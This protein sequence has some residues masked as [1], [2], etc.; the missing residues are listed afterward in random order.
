MHSVTGNISFSSEFE[1]FS[2]FNNEADMY[3][4][5]LY[6]SGIRARYLDTDRGEHVSAYAL[7]LPYVEE[8]QILT[9]T[10]N[11]EFE[12]KD[13]TLGVT[14]DSQMLTKNQARIILEYMMSIFLYR[15]SFVESQF[16]RD[17]I[18][19]EAVSDAQLFLKE[20]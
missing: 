12:K 7:A 19:D 5:L 6:K 1:H 16:V 18:R 4:V 3:M 10:N 13:I 9:I 8:E 11:S 2:C 20:L 15:T 14:V 17:L